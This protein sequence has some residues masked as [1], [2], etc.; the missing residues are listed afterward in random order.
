MVHAKNYET[1]STFVK[2]IQKKTWPFFLD[3]VYVSRT[4]T[5][6]VVFKCWTIVS[7]SQLFVVC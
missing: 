7:F 4:V 2:V 6:C 1:V 3:T 5:D